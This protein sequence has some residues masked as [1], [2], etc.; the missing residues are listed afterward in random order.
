MPKK[1][2]IVIDPGHGGSDPGALSEYG[3]R[4]SDLN[5]SLAKAFIEAASFLNDYDVLTLR[6]SDVFIPLKERADKVN[7]LNPT[8]VLSFHC[9]ASQNH[10]ASGFEVYTTSG[11]TKAD[12]LA[13]HIYE[14]LDVVM[15]YNGRADFDDGDPDKEGPFYIIRKT[16]APAVLIEFGFI[17]NDS[18][19]SWLDG[20]GEEE[21][22]DAVAGAVQTWLDEE[23]MR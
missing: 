10:N 13:T 20:I 3:T 6:D 8:A 21:I 11:D 2:L 18:D 7:A 22:V 19:L 17:T 12:S 9:N 14:A 4:E 5:L 1:P 23:A 15:P 16:I